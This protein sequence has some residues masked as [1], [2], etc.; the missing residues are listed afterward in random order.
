MAFF[1]F[2]KGGRKGTNKAEKNPVSGMEFAK[3]VIL[4]NFEDMFEGEEPEEIAVYDLQG[5][6]VG[7]L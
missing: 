5:K 2:L 6:P 4:E 1:D 7:T 3:G